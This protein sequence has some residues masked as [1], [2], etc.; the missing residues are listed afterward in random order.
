MTKAQQGEW[1]RRDNEEM[2]VEVQA[3]IA[4]TQADAAAREAE[5]Q[6]GAPARAQAGP[7]R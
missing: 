3:E 2:A 1:I 7:P 4:R 6:A 5:W